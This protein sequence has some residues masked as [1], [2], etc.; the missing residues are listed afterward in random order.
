MKRTHTISLALAVLIALLISLAARESAR[1]PERR[2]AEVIRATLG[3]GLRIV[4]LRDPLTPVITV[5]QN[6]LVGA[7]ET[8]DGFPGMAHAQEHMAFRGCSGATAD[9]I[10]AIYAQ[11]GGLG[12]A[13]TQQTITQYFTTVPA[14]DVE[15]A[16]R[17]GAACMRNIVDAQSE[18]LQ[19]KGAIQQEVAR[20]LS[21]PTYKFL[22]RVNEDFFAGTPYAHDALGTHDSFEA[23]TGEM[24][25]RFYDTWYAPNSAILVVAGDVQP[26]ATLRLV[27][28]LYGDI[29]R[30]R[31]PP[32]PDVTFGPVKHERFTLESDLPYALALVAYR[33]PGSDSPDFAPAQILADVLASERGNLYA[34][35]PRGQALSADFEL[36]ATLPKASVAL[37]AAAVPTPAGASGMLDTMRSILADYVRNGV[38]PDLIEAAKR[39]E[40]AEAAF[41]RGSIQGLAAQ[42]SQA[43]A[44]EGRDSPDDALNAIRRV[45]PDDVNR[46]AREFLNDSNSVVATL[47]P[48]AAGEPVASKGFG[49]A[50]QLTPA[51]SKPVALPAWAESALAKLRLPPDPPQSADLRL[52]NLL[53]LIVRTDTS[54]PTVTVLGNV[55]HEASL[56]AA[57]G[58]EGVGDVLE[59]L[60]SYGTIHLDRLAFRKALDDI[61]A[62]ESAGYDFSLQ[63][64]K[65][66][67]PRGVELLADNLLNPALPA[68]GFEVVRQQTAAFLEGE[69]KTPS[70]RASRALLTGLL[71]PG[72]PALREATPRTVAALTLDDVRRYH[73][74]TF[75]PDLTTIVVVGDITAD[76][77]QQTIARWFGEWKA[78][79]PKPNVVLPRIPE[80]S[81]TQVTVPDPTAVQASVVVAEE[82]GV[83]RTDPDYYALQLGDHVLGGGFYATRLYR[84]LRQQTGYVY[85]VDN[86]LRA[87][88]TRSVYAVKYGA[89]LQN[90]AKARDLIVRDLQTMQRDPVSTY[91]LHQAKALLLRRMTLDESSVEAVASGL[92]GRAQAD[93]PLDEPARAARRYFSMPA[94][95]VRAAFAKWIRPEGFVQV[96]RTPQ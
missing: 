84:D 70:Y 50:E 13:D 47:V 39:R 24:L 89:D 14:T 10:A 20:D 38:P 29:P 94:E 15:V 21:S 63:V 61:T 11:L 32:R 36:A 25:K 45:T 79:G 85:T 96:V 28:Q 51:P 90:V 75:R 3:N 58:K 78:I 49:G 46:V 95:E 65:A 7:D 19:E 56:Q 87:D 88:K 40:I 27:E 92:L 80:T 1:R 22:M 60:F 82:L 12:N 53:R 31:L 55:R 18:W 34:L 6:Y 62:S 54:S 16:L 42:W 52:P 8:P 26:D 37:S 57:A 67:F 71:P 9:Q 93:L 72:D 73:A 43:L 86:S 41:A 23:T 48:K 5:Q 2:E 91:E 44:A 69:I 74:S 4:V 81:P 59:E 17:L 64:L 35:V 77:A 83:T 33:F 76:E 30:K 68:E 66:D